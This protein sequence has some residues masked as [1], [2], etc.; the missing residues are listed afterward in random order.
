MS[1][2]MCGGSANK[3]ESKGVEDMR[4]AI[5]RDGGSEKKA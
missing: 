5:F 3:D 2:V 4:E 1:G